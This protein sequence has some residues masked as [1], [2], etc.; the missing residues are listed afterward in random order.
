MM[1]ASP[2]AKPRGS[3]RHAPEPDL[4]RGLILR[5]EHAGKFFKTE[6]PG[7]V[8]T[9]ELRNH[10]LRCVNPGNQFYIVECGHGRNCSKQLVMKVL[11][12][13]TFT[14]NV[15]LAPEVVPNLYDQHFCNAEDFENIKQKWKKKGTVIGWRVTNAQRFDPP[16]WF[17]P[18]SQDSQSHCMPQ[19]VSCS[20]KVLEFVG[21]C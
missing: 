9:L 4:L 5:Q 21:D 19:C 14:E 10:N 13:V 2:A 18:S 16:M 11:G 15:P 12:A 20:S 8:K 7:R 17:C 1:V 3:P 6:V